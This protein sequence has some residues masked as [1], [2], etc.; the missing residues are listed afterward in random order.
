M[1][2][3][4]SPTDTGGA[5]TLRRGLA[6]LSLFSAER[7]VLM[8]AEIAELLGIPLPTVGRLC[9]TLSLDHYLEQDARTRQ[10]RLGPQ[11]MRLA[12]RS[13]TGL[14]EDTRRWMGRLNATFDEDVNIAILD[15]TQALYLDA[16]PST[17]V[18]ST[19]TAVGS[20]ALA[21]CT[22]I[23]KSLLSQ[24][25]DRVVLDRLGTGP[26][27]GRTAHTI[28]RWEELQPELERIRATGI[29]R[30]IDEYEE[31][32][33]GFATPLGTGPGGAPMAL[34]IAVPNARCSPERAEEIVR[35]LTDPI[36]NPNH[37][38]DKHHD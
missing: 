18:L 3:D 37:L 32:L 35:A 13:N 38:G 34:S 5:K 23:G 10:L 16:I 14:T 9:R 7:P 24:L 12:G 20:R 2:N 1:Q 30:S 19:Q 27:E 6:I 33:S 21:H 17:K 26:Y 8:Q 36:Q 29:S 11:I 15:G 31:G 22:A 28:R 4:I 25:D